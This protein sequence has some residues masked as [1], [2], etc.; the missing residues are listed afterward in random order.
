[1]FACRKPLV[2]SLAVLVAFLA[3]AQA[4]EPD[5][6]PGKGP[7]KKFF[8]KK[9]FFEKKFKKTS[10]ELE[11]A[12]A[13]VKELE[14]QME[15]LR[16]QLKETAIKLKKAQAEVAEHDGERGEGRFG[17]ARA[18]SGFGSGFGGGSQRPPWAQGRGWG[19]PPGGW[20]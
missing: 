5:K 16:E 2:L 6:K 4:Q 11:K 15:T 18:G 1:M 7:D 20:S 14:A 12:R 3:V 10:S 8:D 13:E 17:G 9:A 19:P